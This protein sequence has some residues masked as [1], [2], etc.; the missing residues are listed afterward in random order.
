LCPASGYDLV[1]PKSTSGELIMIL[2][3]PE[4]F[5]LDLCLDLNINA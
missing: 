2:Q 1:M 4:I 3:L 5:V